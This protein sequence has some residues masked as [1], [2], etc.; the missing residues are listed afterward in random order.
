MANGRP[1]TPVNTRPDGVPVG[2]W[3]P[4]KGERPASSVPAPRHTPVAVPHD[5]AGLHRPS[6]GGGA[7]TKRQG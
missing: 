7:G 4:G 6:H 5:R 2:Q 1:A 3:H